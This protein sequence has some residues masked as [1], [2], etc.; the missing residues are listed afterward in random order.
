M[1]RTAKVVTL[2]FKPLPVV[3]LAIDPGAQ[4]GSAIFSRGDLITHFPAS[5]RRSYRD[6]IVSTARD[7]SYEV[8]CPLVAVMETWSPQGDWGFNAAMGLAEQAGRW[9]DSLEA[10]G[11]PKIVRV[12]P[13]QWRRALWKMPRGTKTEQWKQRALDHARQVFSVSTM[14]DNTAEAIAIGHWATRAHAVKERAGL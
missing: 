7:L 1:P 8:S 10:H 14:N 5:R 11:V 4:D 13:N 6:Q 3:I 12:K 2:Q 9:L